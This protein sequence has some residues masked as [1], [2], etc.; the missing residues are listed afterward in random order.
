V[1][2]QERERRIV[3]AKNSSERGRVQQLI[4]SDLSRR[5]YFRFLDGQLEEYDCTKYRTYPV[6]ISNAENEGIARFDF[7][8]SEYR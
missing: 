4:I 7:F 3:K 5:E 6:R 8:T 1:T 2:T